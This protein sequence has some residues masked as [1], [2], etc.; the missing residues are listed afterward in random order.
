MSAR[1]WEIGLPAGLG[2]E[3]LAA[4][5]FAMAR[6]ACVPRLD[7]AAV[8]LV[9]DAPD[10]NWPTDDTVLLAKTAG[11][12]VFRGLVAAG[13]FDGHSAVCGMV[14]EFGPKSYPLGRLRIII[15]E[16]AAAAEGGAA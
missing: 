5:A 6:N 2:V 1:E 11:E 4:A 16:A 7:Y 15:R 8:R 3:S 14:G 13:V 9:Y 10:A 12:P